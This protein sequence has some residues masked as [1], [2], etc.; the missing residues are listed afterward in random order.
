MGDVDQVKAIKTQIDRLSKATA[1]AV[2]AL[3]KKVAALK[4]END[5]LAKQVKIN[6]SGI[7]LLERKLKLRDSE[8][9]E[10]KAEISQMR[11]SQRKG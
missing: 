11:N 5:K 2:D 9:Y 3:E 6:T 10:L 1:S 8:I 4:K 7:R